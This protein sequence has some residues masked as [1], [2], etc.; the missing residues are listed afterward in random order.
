MSKTKVTP[1]KDDKKV[2]S[3]DEPKKRVARKPMTVNEPLTEA[4]ADFDFNLYR[5]LKKRDFAEE[6]LFYEHKAMEM[7]FK[8]AQYR[9]D[10]AES[11]KLGSSKDR[12]AARRL[13][14]MTE[15]M[16]E[17]QAQLVAAGVDVDALLAAQEK[18]SK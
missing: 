11:K 12:A 6:H 9:A 5:P 13:V 16:A 15:K 7:E 14:K 2:V 4:P 18:A 17:L 1:K 10:A 3:T 8:A